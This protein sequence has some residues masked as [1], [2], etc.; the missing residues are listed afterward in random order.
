MWVCLDRGVR[1][2]DKYSRSALNKE[3]WTKCRDTLYEEVMTKGYDPKIKSFVMSYGTQNLDSSLLI[4]PLVLFISA[5]DPRILSTIEAIQQTP[6]KGGLTSNTLVYRYNV[7]LTD[8]GLCGTE[9]TFNMCTFWLIEALA[10]AGDRD[11]KRLRQA[12][13]K[14]EQMLTYANHLGLYAEQTGHTGFALG[15]FPQSFTHMALISTAFNLN[16]R[17]G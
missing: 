16:K 11:V 1:L 6:A 13:L 14:F 3:K 8:D 17:L 10:R 5:T 15:N 4:L 12:Q 2:A 9:G 7:E